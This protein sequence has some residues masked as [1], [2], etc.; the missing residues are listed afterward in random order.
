M[1][2]LRGRRAMFAFGEANA[3]IMAKA[4]PHANTS[5]RLAFRKLLAIRMSPCPHAAGY[6]HGT[7]LAAHSQKPGRARAPARSPM[8]CSSGVRIIACPALP[9]RADDQGHGKTVLHRSLTPPLLPP[10]ELDFGQ[11]SSFCFKGP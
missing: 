9:R 7:R 1:I 10:F 11:P 5:A 3:G 8:A 4:R 6:P 2:F